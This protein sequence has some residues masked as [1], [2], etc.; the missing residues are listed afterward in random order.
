MF[1][2]LA[3][4]V[5]RTFWYT[6]PVEPKGPNKD[7]KSVNVSQ[8]TK[9]HRAKTYFKENTK[10]YRV[11]YNTSEQPKKFLIFGMNYVKKVYFTPSNKMFKTNRGSQKT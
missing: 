2:F 4:L 8:E 5:C 10:T 11:I 3:L 9:K 6:M 7:S 1:Y